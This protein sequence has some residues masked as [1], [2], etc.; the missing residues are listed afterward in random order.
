MIDF[1]RANPYITKDEYLWEWTVPQ[2]RLATFD[3]THIEY[4]SEDEAKE[5]K[6]ASKVKSYD[7]PMDLVND[8]GIPIFNDVK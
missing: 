6:K 4:L 1:L 3:Y 5:A 8:L 2:I 7:N